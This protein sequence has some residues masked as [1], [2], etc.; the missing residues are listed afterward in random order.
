MANEKNVS[1]SIVV[2]GTPVEV[3][4]NEQAAVASLIEKALHASG[5]VGQ[6]ASNWRLTDSNGEPVDNNMKIGAAIAGNIKLY[7]TLNAGVA[8]GR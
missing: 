2:N 1:V 6:P 7:L 4:G 5:N 8:G 3:D